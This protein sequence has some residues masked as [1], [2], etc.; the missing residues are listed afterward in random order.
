MIIYTDNL[1]TIIRQYDGLV[2]TRKE[3][4]SDFKN[5][6]LELQKQAVVIKEIFNHIKED[7]DKKEELANKMQDL[8]DKYGDLS[9]YVNDIQNTTQNASEIL[10]DMQ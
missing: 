9:S 6:L 10:E 4:I 8:Q 2:L 1:K 5:E 7:V 3:Y